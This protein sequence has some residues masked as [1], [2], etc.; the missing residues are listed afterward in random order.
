MANS[1]KHKQYSMA[2]SKW[3]AMSQEAQ[4]EFLAANQLQVRGYTLVGRFSTPSDVEFEDRRV[5]A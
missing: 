1:T 4:L 3:E 5:F 2:M